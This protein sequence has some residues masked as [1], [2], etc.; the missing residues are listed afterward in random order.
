[1]AD[2]TNDADDHAVD[3]RL[4]D[5]GARWRDSLPSSP[6]PGPY[7]E[8]RRGSLLMPAAAVA[9]VAMVLAIAWAAGDRSNDQGLRDPATAAGAV[10][11][12]AALPTTDPVLPT[13]DGGPSAQEIKAARP[14]EA[15]D[16]TMLRR[17]LEPAMGTAYLTVQ[18]AL[19]GPTPCRVEGYPDVFLLDPE[20]AVLDIEVTLDTG[21][22]PEPVLV[23][24]T[25]PAAVVVSWSPSHY[26]SSVDNARIRIG[27]PDNAGE[28]TVDGFGPTTCNPDEGRPAPRVR[29]VQPAYADDGPTSPYEQVT[30][31]GDLDLSVAVG[32]PIDFEITL[33][34][35]VDLPLDPCPDYEIL[36]A[37]RVDYHGL[38]CAAVPY[39]DDEG[40][41][42]LPAGVPVTFAMHAPAFDTSVFI[43][44]FAWVLTAPGHPTAGGTVEIGDAAPPEGRVTG[45]VTMDGGPAPGT[46]VKVTEGTVHARGLVDRSAPIVAGQFELQ[47]PAGRY[48]LWATSPQYGDGEA[49]CRP[50]ALPDGLVV[51]AGQVVAVAISCQMR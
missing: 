11:P 14:C 7:A 15:G 27:I 3:R 5:Y 35:P 28:V 24:P 19:E 16:L 9:V 40:R 34:S 2:P 51:E 42:Y 21:S 49:D 20:G 38:N 23:T 13:I 50:I 18:L 26:C 46:S 41:P 1:M 39:V 22:A 32:A 30:A 33:T 17:A 8:R 43:T 4:T 6:A 36:V 44:K 12:W 48:D 31:T 29:P 45:L 47:L 25:E 37:P 10:V